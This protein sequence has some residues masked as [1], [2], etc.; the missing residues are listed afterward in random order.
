MLLRLIE[1]LIRGDPPEDLHTVQLEM[2]QSEVLDSLLVSRREIRIVR[3]RELGER[4]R[5]DGRGRNALAVERSRTIGLLESVS[6]S[7]AAVK[8]EKRRERVAM[9]GFVVEDDLELLPFL[10][11]NVAGRL[12]VGVLDLV[13]RHRLR[14]DF[15]M[16]GELAGGVLPAKK[17]EEW[18]SIT[19]WERKEKAHSLVMVG[20]MG[21][22]ATRKLNRESNEA[23]SGWRRRSGRTKV[24]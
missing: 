20:M 12:V 1:R 14:V 7:V 22:I 3:R 23:R 8:F 24:S 2:N 4:K 5:A 13:D 21:A 6:S 10:R 18:A 11:L 15:N 16:G 19:I 9:V 17:G